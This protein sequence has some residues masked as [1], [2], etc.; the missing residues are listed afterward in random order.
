MQKMKPATR[1]AEIEPRKAQD[2]QPRMVGPPSSGSGSGA[3]FFGVK[4]VEP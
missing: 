2:S 1:W 4:Y 3:P